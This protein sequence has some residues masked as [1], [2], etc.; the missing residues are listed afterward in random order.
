[1][2]PGLWTSYSFSLP[3]FILFLLISNSLLASCQNCS[4]DNPCA[5]GC[6]SKDGWCGTTEEHCGEGNSQSSSSTAGYC[7]HGPEFCAPENC[8]SGCESK[9][10]CDP[11]F[12]GK[13]SDSSKCPLNVCCSDFGFCGTTKEFCGDKTVTHPS[14]DTAKATLDRVVR[15]Y[16][17]WASRRPCNA[18]WP[19]QIPLGVYTHINF[20]FA[21]IDPET[22]EVRPKTTQDLNLLMRVTQLKTINPDLKV[23]IALG[24][25]TFN[26]PGPT[27]TTFS[28]IA[29]SKANQQKFFKS[30]ISFI[31]THNLD[32]PEDFKNFPTF[33]SNLK[34]AL[35]SSGGRNKLSITLPTSYWYLRHFNIVSLARHRNSIDSSKVVLGLAFYARVYTLKDPSCMKPGCIF[36]SGGE[37]GDYSQEVG[38]LLNSKI[39]QIVRSIKLR[40]T[41]YKDA[42]AQVLSWG[43]Q[44]LSYDNTKT[45][46]LKADYTRGSCLGGVMVWAISHNTKDAKW[47]AT[48]NASGLITASF[49]RLGGR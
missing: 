40:S 20:A 10:E 47:R 14:C 24:G 48:Y 36:A 45:L 41:F 30:L 35:D 32:G 1:M 38:I 4:K 34:S 33:I 25:W 18:F 26:D 49:A 9:S 13:W 21:A 46:K 17:A 31:S 8:V 19:E 7:G 22:F 27:Q 23:L 6:C 37:Q 43:N 42:A 11:G 44:W 12:G 28:D 29:G 3:F 5:T 16:K 15:Y 2:K 39:D